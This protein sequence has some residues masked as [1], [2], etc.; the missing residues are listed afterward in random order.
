MMHRQYL[1]SLFTDLSSFQWAVSPSSLQDGTLC[2]SDQCVIHSLQCDKKRYLFRIIWQ[3]ASLP[4]H[5]LFFFFSSETSFSDIVVSQLHSFL[6]Q[7]KNN[8]WN[9]DICEVLST[10]GC[11]RFQMRNFHIS[12]MRHQTAI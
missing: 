7:Q 11:P 4:S 6:G 8:I 2:L 10:D 5:N 12:H 9:N 3:S 1:Q